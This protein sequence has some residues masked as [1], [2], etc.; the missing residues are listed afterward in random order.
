METTLD[1]IMVFGAV[2]FVLYFG[3]GFLKGKKK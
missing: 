3:I 2:A 1:Y